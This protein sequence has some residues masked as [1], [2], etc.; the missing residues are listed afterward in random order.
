[1][2]RRKD[3]TCLW[4]CGPRLKRGTRHRPWKSTR[5]AGTPIRTLTTLPFLRA[6]T[7]G[8]LRERAEPSQRVTPPP[9]YKK[10]ER[11]R[12]RCNTWRRLLETRLRFVCGHVMTLGHDP[13]HKNCM[14]LSFKTTPAQTVVLR[15]G[16]MVAPDVPLQARDTQAAQSG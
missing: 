3:H 15:V 12:T 5:P 6:T 1:M 11:M 8:A 2:T 7:Y 9:Y 16:A 4:F 14:R 13:E 10:L